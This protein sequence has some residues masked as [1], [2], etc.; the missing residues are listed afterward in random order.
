MMKSIHGAEEIV[1]TIPPRD[2]EMCSEDTVQDIVKSEALATR[3]DKKAAMKDVEAT[4]QNL[5]NMKNVSHLLVATWALL[6]IAVLGESN[7]SYVRQGCFEVGAVASDPVRSKSLLS[8]DRESVTAV[9]A[10]SRPNV[11]EPA[12][13]SNDEQMRVTRTFQHHTSPYI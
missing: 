11:T 12:Y 1:P 6:A 9:D 7:G 5:Y 13:H 3:V 8:V 10:A 2:I 4:C